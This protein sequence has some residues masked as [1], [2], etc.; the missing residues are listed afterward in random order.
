LAWSFA[1]GVQ[2]LVSLNN[3]GVPAN[4]SC[5]MPSISAD[6]SRIAFLSRANNLALVAQFSNN[7]YLRDR[8]SGS[9]MLVSATADGLP[10]TA[11]STSVSLSSNGNFAAHASAAA[12]TPGHSGNGFDAFLFEV[13]SRRSVRVSVPVVTPGEPNNTGVQ[14]VG[15]ISDSGLACLFGSNASNLING[16]TLDVTPDVYVRDTRTPWFRDRDGDRFGKSDESLSIPFPSTLDYSLV[17]GDCDDTR[18]SVNPAAIE[19]CNGLDDDC[20]GFV[21]EVAWFSYCT[22]STSQQGC[23]PTLRVDGY[24][25]AS[26]NAGFF[27]RVSGLPA[28]RPAVAMFGTALTNYAW[29]FGSTSTVCV[30][31]P[32]VRMASLGSGGNSGSC[33][34]SYSVD[35]LAFMTAHPTV[36]GH[37]VLP[38]RA[39]YVQVW[40]RDPGAPLNSNLTDAIAFTLCP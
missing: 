31:A 39:Y 11:A 35:W 33:N 17:S 21:D 26:Q 12:L 2:E 28:Q 5:S 38:G 18:P 32:R 25:S 23:S 22:A 9:V 34:G 19:T 1:S 29:S 40:Y 8:T 24:P 6:G 27:V 16:D 20:D 4:N 13:S 10:A 15:G 37:P 36:P 30:A 14:E 7:A 3:S